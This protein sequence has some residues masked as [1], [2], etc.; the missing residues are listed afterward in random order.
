V[1]ASF[2]AALEPQQA[3]EQLKAYDYGQELTPLVAI[4]AL[5]DQSSNDPPQ[6]KQ[7]TA[8]LAA[9]LQEPKTSQAAKQFI[10]RQLERIGTDEQVPILAKMLDDPQASEFARRALQQIPGDAASAALREALARAQGDARIGLIN[11]LGERRDPKAADAL[12][13]LIADPDAKIARA[14]VRALGKLGTPE[15]LAALGKAMEGAKPELAEA[16]AHARLRCADTLVAA[17]DAA[18]ADAAY[19]AIYLRAPGQKQPSLFRIAALSGLVS[20]LPRVSNPREVTSLVIE[21]LGDP[22]P[23]LRGVAAALAKRF[24]GKEFTAA[25]LA[26]LEKADQNGQV[27]VLDILAE[28]GD[29][30][31]RAAVTRLAESQD[32]AVKVAAI[33]ALGQ[34]GDRSSIE[35]LARLAATSG[36]AVQQ[37]A[38]EGMARLRQANLGAE[39]MAALAAA[40]DKRETGQAVELIEALAARGSREA[41]PMLDA[42]AGK[43]SPIVRLAALKALGVLADAKHYPLLIEHVLAAKTEADE[44]AAEQAVLK[45]AGRVDSAADRMRPVLGALEKASSKKVPALLRLLGRDRGP[46]ALSLVRKWANDP[47]DV[48][49][50]AAIRCLAE[51]PTDEVADD[52]LKLAQ[53]AQNPTHRVLALRGYLRM[54]RT[55]KRLE[56]ALPLVKAT[57]EKLAWLAASGDVADPAALSLAARFLDDTPVRAEAILATLKIADAVVGTDPAAVKAPMQKVLDSR[58]EKSIADHAQAL[59]EGKRGFVP[60]FDGKTLKGWASNGV[61]NW[62]VEDGAIVGHGTQKPGYGMLFSERPYK[63]FTLRFRY[64]VLAGNAGFYIRA[65]KLAGSNGVRG[66]QVEIDPVK[67][68]G[69]LYEVGGRDWVAK[70]D[71]K[72]PK[73][74]FRPRDWNDVT[75]VAQGRH[76]T[77]T[78]NGHKAVELP[79][80]PGRTEGFF[81]LGMH[82]GGVHVIFKDIEVLTAP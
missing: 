81:A 5:I 33:R 15:A 70:P 69:G 3:F 76:F 41:V 34:L 38:R 62:S 39:M 1:S 48:A 24:T 9:I 37:A 50:D 13:K 55:A 16:I 10:C 65:E 35:L 26:L 29:G 51:W 71:P 82:G 73:D 58:P 12:A 64:K 79:N 20:N 36:G 32:E 66:L 78:M 23:Q 19:L 61:G 18:A 27:A 17:G 28:R 59:L 43:G 6:R 44:K 56:L 47:A 42:L 72:L 49:R 60:L 80:D 11:S 52:L 54:A 46:E 31:A 4:E 67:D 75:V 45:L 30:T 74:H 8:Q 7:I 14:A 25:I 63:D 57:E 21:S 40:I 2:G 22:N 68:N 53:E 77:V